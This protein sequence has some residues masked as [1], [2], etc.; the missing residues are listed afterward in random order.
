MDTKTVTRIMKRSCVR[1]VDAAFL[2]SDG[3]CVGGSASS[4]LGA[5][6]IGGRRG[7]VGR[8]ILTNL[9]Y[10]FLC[11]YMYN[12]L[13]IKVFLLASLV[14]PRPRHLTHTTTRRDSFTYCPPSKCALAAFA[15]PRSV[16]LS[17]T[18]PQPWPHASARPTGSAV[19]SAPQAPRL[20]RSMPRMAS[21]VRMRTGEH[22]PAT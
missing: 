15:A 9:Q 13:T 22:M 5:T 11:R 12:I 6:T 16:C 3:G 1:S 21:L 20:S 14:L 2:T 17:S 7:R 8:A 19:E 18:W 10:V 4:L